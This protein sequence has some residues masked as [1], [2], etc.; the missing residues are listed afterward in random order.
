L[1]PAGAARNISWRRKGGFGAALPTHW[2]GAMNPQ[3]N[4]ETIYKDFREPL[5]AFLSKRVSDRESAEDLLHDIFIKIHTQIG[6][7]K[8]QEK[9]APWIYRIARNAL[10]DSFRKQRETI[11]SSEDLVSF[12]QAETKDLSEKLDRMVRAMVNQLPY[13]YK[14]ALLLS[15]FQGIKQAE[16][17][18]R[19]DISISGAKSRIQRARAMLKDLLLQCCHFEFDRYGTVF[20]YYPKECG[21]CCVKEKSC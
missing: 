11:E 13:Q 9:L 17:A 8:E 18:R 5:K 2:K 14:E 3:L 10:I 1:R 6:S 20:D 21:R 16:I 12:H 4:L 19:L 7:L 15:D